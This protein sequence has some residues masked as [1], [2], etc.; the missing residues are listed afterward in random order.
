VGARLNIYY[1][2]DNARIYVLFCTTIML[3]LTNMSVKRKI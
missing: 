1:W 3:T 2:S